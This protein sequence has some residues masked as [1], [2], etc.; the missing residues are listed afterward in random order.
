MHKALGWV[1]EKKISFYNKK[2]EYSATF[3][4]LESIIL[5]EKSQANRQIHRDRVVF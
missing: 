2:E 5:S 4:N 1:N 3:I